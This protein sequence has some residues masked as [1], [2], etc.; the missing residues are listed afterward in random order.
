MDHR[1]CNRFLLSIAA[2]VAA[3]TGGL[4]AARSCDAAG[5]IT[6]TEHL[7]VG[8]RNRAYRLHLP[9]AYDGVMPLPLV[10][11]FHGSFETAEDIERV[12][13][14]SRLADAQ[15]V[16]VV[17]PEGVRRRWNDGRSPVAA[18]TD[19]VGF[20]TALITR[21]EDTLA[22]DPTRIYAAGM[23]NGG[24]FV[25][26]LGCELSGIIAAIAPVDGT[27]PAGVA[28]S[29]RPAQ[30]VSVIEFHGTKDAYVLWHGGMV[31]V[32]GG[33]T[34]S[35][36]DTV[37]QWRQQDACP[38]RPRVVEEPPQDPR[39]SMRVRR[40][41]YGPCRD[42]NDVVLYTVEGGGHTWPG[43]PEDPLIFTGRVN[44]DVSATDVIWAFFAQH[45]KR[46]ATMLAGAARPR[47]LFQDA[48]AGRSSP[49]SN[50]PNVSGSRVTSYVLWPFGILSDVVQLVTTLSTKYVPVSAW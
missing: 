29:C 3:Q 12:T 40:E 33:R 25:Q 26:R 9:P 5:A 30:P 46:S 41:T 45:P 39:A 27:M 22:I 11:V 32:L 21:L 20:V 38:E 34:L 49:A 2:L 14:F 35:V 36:P 28:A 6:R 37:A 23:S 10:L 47:T 50:L 15:R 44:R 4:A 13:Q 18:R 24:M 17:Y 7:Q 43:G 1:R 19:D 31:R 42:R 16:I 8:A 48:A